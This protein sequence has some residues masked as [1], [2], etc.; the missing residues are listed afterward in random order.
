MTVILLALAAACCLGTGFVLQ[1]IAAQHAPPQDYLSFRLLLDLVR[2]PRWVAGIV[3]MVTGMALGAVALGMG[4]ITLVEPL[5][6]TNLLFAMALA[7]WISRQ[8]LGRSGWAG[9]WLLAG[10]VTAFIVAGQPHG[11]RNSEVGQLAQWLIMGGVLSTALLLAAIAKRE[12]VHVSLEAALLG[13][14]AGLLYGL[15]DALTRISG[16]R[17]GAGGWRALLTSWHPYAIVVLGVLAL[18]MVQSAF[19]SAPLRMSL[20]ALTAAQPLAGIACGVG[21]LGDQLRVTPGALAF[22]AAGIAAVV[23][24]IVLIGSH[25]AMPP[26]A[27][28]TD[29]SRELQPR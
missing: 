19:E 7:R 18:V 17:F 14:A 12:R 16:L 20:P 21:F 26:G 3:L 11:G 10:G 24:G 1:Q 23:A 28:A 5:M 27:G 22:Q 29:S 6:A 4:D 15:Q 13:V 25:P 2:M 8:R 9:L